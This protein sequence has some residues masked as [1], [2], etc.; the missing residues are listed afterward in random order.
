MLGEPVTEDESGKRKLGLEQAV[1]CGAI[2]AAVAIVDPLVRQNATSLTRLH[3]G[4]TM[5]TH[6]THDTSNSGIDHVV[7]RPK[8][9][10]MHCLVVNLRGNGSIEF[11]AVVSA[12]KVQ[13]ERLTL[14]FLP[15]R[16]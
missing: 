15:Y 4:G 1:D 16:Q 2:L 6:T 13:D 11:I 3:D 5:T 7:E 12:E 10:F 8:V 14:H 9:D